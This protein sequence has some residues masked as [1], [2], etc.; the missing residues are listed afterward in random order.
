MINKFTVTSLCFAIGIICSHVPVLA[1]NTDQSKQSGVAVEAEKLATDTI[2]NKQKE[3]ARWNE[4]IKQDIA[5]N[6][7]LTPYRVRLMY[8]AALEKQELY[9]NKS[10]VLKM[11][12][13]NFEY[14]PEELEKLPQLLQTEEAI[15]DQLDPSK[16]DEMEK[17]IQTDLAA[18][19]AKIIAANKINPILLPANKQ[20]GPILTGST[21]VNKQV[22]AEEE[23]NK[24]IELMS[25]LTNPEAQRS[26]PKRLGK[27]SYNIHPDNFNYE[28]N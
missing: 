14:T 9:K 19:V 5:N 22:S 3:D 12:T 15:L 26:G 21:K 8:Q 1:Q 20:D 2:S 27:R 11:L 17:L 10:E 7:N 23:Q 25:G 13:D 18:A 4:I 24:I 28:K 16:S 6:R